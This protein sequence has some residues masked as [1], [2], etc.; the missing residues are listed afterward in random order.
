MCCSGAY[1][2]RRL[3]YDMHADGVRVGA[4]EEEG[5]LTRR[6]VSDLRRL[7]GRASDPLAR[8]L[9]GSGAARDCFWVGEFVSMYEQAG[10]VGVEAW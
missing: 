6:W 7:T 4:A 5:R 9:K 1:V 8:G 3:G 2:R 10:V